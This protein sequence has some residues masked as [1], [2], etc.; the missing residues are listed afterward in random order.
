MEAN[1]LTVKVSGKWLRKLF[2][3]CDPV[4]VNRHCLGKGCCLKKKGHGN[5]L[6]GVSKSEALPLIKAGAIIEDG[7]LVPEERG[8]CIACHF[9]DQHGR[10]TIFDKP[11]RP[12]SCWASPFTLRV[13]SKTVVLVVQR[14]VTVSWPCYKCSNYKTPAYIAH[15]VSLEALFGK[16]ETD[17]IIEQ[18]EAGEISGFAEMPMENFVKLQ[19]ANMH[20]RD[21]IKRGK[22]PC[23]R[24]Q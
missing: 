13:Y 17:R 24:R 18:L 11:W 16:P 1:T 21:W 23:P 19:E 3:P 12:I 9:V 20:K 5:I 14:R 15:R 22:A 10:C 2:A 6:V 4:F 7:I 8:D